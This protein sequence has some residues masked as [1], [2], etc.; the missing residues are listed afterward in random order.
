MDYQKTWVGADRQSIPANKT[1]LPGTWAFKLKRLPDGL[2]LKYKAI[3][4]VRGDKQIVGVEYFETYAPVVQWSII[5][6]VLTMVLANGWVTRQVDYTNAFT[7]AKLKEKVYIEAPKEFQRKDERDL[8]LKLLKSLYGLK[9]APKYF[10]DKL[11][12]GLIERGFKQSEFNKCLFINKDMIGVVYVDDK[13][14]A[15]PKFKA[16]EDFI[17]SLGISDD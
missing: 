4:R 3:Y 13:I 14:I 9:Q 6:L 16:I 12:S 5:R 11:S 15:R 8:V 7:K 1:I 17:P 2:P 10:F